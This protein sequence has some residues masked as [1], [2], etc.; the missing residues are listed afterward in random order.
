MA[1]DCTLLGIGEVRPD[2]GWHLKS[3]CHSFYELILPLAGRMEVQ[4]AG[5]HLEATRGHVLLYPPGVHHEESSVPADPVS[6]LFI[7][8]HWPSAGSGLPCRVADPD[9]RI[10]QGL[11]W[12][13][14]DRDRPSSPWLQDERERLLGFILARF[15]TIARMPSGDDQ[16]VDR[17]R[18]YIRQHLTRRIRLDE[19]A[20]LAGLSRFH[21]LRAYRR[22]AGR[23][24]LAD[25]R[26]LRLNHAR[27]LLLTTNLG[28]KQIAPR[29]GFASEFAL[30]RA[31]SR[32]FG[33]PAS[34]LRQHA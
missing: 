16:M 23:P 6:T 5:Q 34:T 13:F 18:A 11:Q 10:R 14:A 8:F 1:G 28:L 12:L 2:A 25:V 24:P 19:L 21:F 33:Q 3:H 30:S 29:C 22:R 26:A 27:E 9:G 17:T 15:Q 20:A 32:H 7:S 31:F 4:I